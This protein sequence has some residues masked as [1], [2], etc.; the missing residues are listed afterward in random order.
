MKKILVILGHPD[1]ESFN[2]ALFAKYVNHLDK[3]KA[4]IKTIE[5]GKL[6]FNPNLQFGYRKRTDLEP[7]LLESQEKIK[8]ADHIVLIF[9]LWWGSMPA[10]LK[11]FFDRILLPGFA[12]KKKDD[13]IWWEKYLKGKSARIILTM[14][15]PPLYFRLAFK[16][17]AYNAV[18]KMTFQ[19]IGIQRVK[20]NAIG[21]VRN[22]KL[23]K[24]EAWL[25]KMA[26]LAR[27]DSN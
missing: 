6:D 23:K 5:V 21:T 25:A 4:E 24:R 9:P 7:D 12:F 27:K 8:W 10:I 20:Y 11:G 3:S 19:F 1:Q 15:Q 18:K 16:R 14:D 13:S 22:S 2:Q 26:T 17:P